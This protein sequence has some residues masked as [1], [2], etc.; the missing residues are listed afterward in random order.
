M[1]IRIKDD[2]VEIAGYVNAVERTSRT[3]S[4]RVGK[5]V[6]KVSKG[7]FQR[8]ID[9]AEDIECKLNH[10]R[11][12]GS[13]SQ[14]NLSLHEDAIG[15][16]AEFTTDDAEVVKDARD[17]NL[18]GWSFGFYDVPNGVEMRTTDDGLP[19]R[20]VNDMDL[21]EVSIINKEKVPAYEGTLIMARSDD[22]VRLFGDIMTTEMS[23]KE[24]RSQQEEPVGDK[25]VVV[26]KEVD[27]SH[28]EQMIAEMK[29]E[30]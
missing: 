15:L 24:E 14:G 3:L 27:Y 17:G 22:D 20:V 6:E 26:D 18:V 4:S 7:A 11:T 12:L 23:I 29:G 13:V 21:R 5:F 1:E 28:Y 8:A 25:E 9:S 10:E 30:E 19:L 2:T 16:K